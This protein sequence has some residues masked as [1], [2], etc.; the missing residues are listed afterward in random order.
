[1]SSEQMATYKIA[2]IATDPTTGKARC[3]VSKESRTIRDY[4]SFDTA[5]QLVNERAEPGDRLLVDY[6]DGTTSEH[7][8]IE[9]EHDLG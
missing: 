5:M 3:R 1:M 7:D 2:R 9:E 6:G 4:A 8:V